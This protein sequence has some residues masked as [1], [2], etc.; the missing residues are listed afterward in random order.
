MEEQVK[1]KPHICCI[2]NLAPHY[3]ANIFSMMD[4]ELS[5]HFYLGDKVSSEIESMDYKQLKGF[6]KTLKNKKIGNTVFYWQKGA[7][8]TILKPYS[9][10]LITGDW[11]CL[12]NWILLFSSFLFSKKIY[13]WAHGWNGNEPRIERFVKKIFF[14]L[15]TKTFLYG[16]YARDLMI[17]NGF[18]PTKLVCIYN[19]L[20][21]DEQ[22][23]IRKGIKKTS[24]YLNHFNNRNPVIFYIGRIQLHK[25]INLLIEA[26]YN[27]KAKGINC[28]LVLIGKEVDDKL[29]PGLVEKLQLKHAVWFYGPCF[30]EEK[31]G[32]LLFNADLCVSPGSVGLT[33]IH[34]LTYGTPVV[35]HNNFKKQMPEFEAITA[36]LCG[37]FYEENN[38]D[39]LCEKIERW[40][41]KNAVEREDIRQTAYKIIN[42]RY[43]P[44]Y[45]I[46]TFKRIILNL[47]SN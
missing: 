13:F 23:K 7:I 2:F 14:G 25:K 5:A 22:T 30:E 9:S 38:V 21:Y 45:Q 19:S 43:N 31:V 47:S 24:I 17:E 42:E 4:K 28:N 46:D 3:R 15:S 41:Y 8:S 40:I 37:D 44:H 34:S 18:D 11:V 20:D 16:N 1:M 26:I 35:S 10:Y 32:E 6:Q 36:G 33:A 29:L 27:L 12:S 39:D